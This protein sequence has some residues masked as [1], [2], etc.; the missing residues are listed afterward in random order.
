MSRRLKKI[1][2]L[3][4]L[5]ILF[6]GASAAEVFA[7]GKIV[8]HVKDKSTGEALI[9]VNIII[10]GSNL[11]AATDLEG[12]YTI[13]NVPVGQYTLKA[14]MV[15]ATSVS[16]QG[17]VVSTDQI[18]RVDF[19]LEQT[20][21]QGEEVVVTAPRDVL[22]K[23]VSSSQIVVDAKQLDETA[24]TR[25]LQ[26]FLNTQ[27]G[28]TDESYLE[29]R[30]GRPGETGTMV[31]GLTFVNA[32]VGKSEAFIPTSAI[33]QVSLKAGGMTAEYGEFRSGLIGVTTKTGSVTGYHGSFSFSKSPSHLKRFGPSLFDP[34]NNYLRPHL[35]PSIAFIGVSAAVQQGIISS[36]EAQQFGQYP[37][38]AGWNNL[39]GRNIPASW[40]NSLKPGE[41]ITPVDLYLFDAWMHTVVPDFNKLNSTIRD[42]NAQG[43]N[44][45]NEVTDQSLI[46]LFKN[47]ANKEDK[48]GDFNFD[49]GFGGP[50]PFL[51]QQLG[52]ATFYLSNITSRTS[53]I[54]PMELDYDLRSATLLTLKSNITQSLTLKLTG[55]YSYRKGMNPARAADSE[56]A[57]LSGANDLSPS[58][59]SNVY[60][61]LDRGALMPENNIPLFVSSGGNYGPTYYWYNTMLQPWEEKNI[62]TGFELT[63]A[64]SA[65]TFYEIT[66]SY[67]RTRDNINPDLSS[68][69]S[70]KIL[71]YIGPIP[72]TEMPYGRNQLPVGQSVDTIGGF[73][74]DQYFQIP[75]LSERFDSKGGS[76]YDN[77][78]TQQLRLKFDF[79]SQITKEHFIKAGVE[80]NSVALDNNRW[81]YWPNQGPLS[82]Y[83]YNFSVYP[84]NLGAFVQD[85]ITFEDMIAT[86]GVRMDYYSFG[87]LQW[88]TGNPWDADAFAPPN[89]TPVVDPNDSSNTTYYLDLLQNGQSLVWQHWNEINAQYIADGKSPFLQPVATHL[90]FSPRFGISFPIS[91]N[92]KFYFNYGHYRSMPPLAD[93]LAYDFR[94]DTQKGGIYELGNPNLA[95]SKTIQYELGVDY[96]LVDQYLIKIAGYYK[97]VSGDVRAITFRPNSGTGIGAYR[98][99]TNDSY[100]TIQGLELQITKNVGEILT[101]WLNL[102]YT[103]ASGGATG[104]TD[105]Y[106]DASTNATTGFYY[107]NPS[108]PYPVPEIRANINLRSP[109]SW[110]YILGGWNLSVLPNWRDGNRFTFNPRG[111]DEGSS[112][113][114]YWP[115]FWMV[116]L[117]VSKSFDVGL[118]R[119][120]AYLNVNNVFNSKQFLYNYAFYGGSG[121][122]SGTDYEYYMRSLHLADYQSSYYDPIRDETAGAYLYP[123]YVYT[124]NVT[125][126]MGISHS[127]GEKVSGEDKVGDMHSSS[128]PW[129]NSPNADLF[130]YGYTRSVWLGIKFDF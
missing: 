11:G 30:G 125:D 42:L 102:Q 126:A 45:G 34:M 29:I 53:Y 49:G 123:G 5:L 116:N 112:N 8:G 52:N 78:L 28:I 9:G 50:V 24:G 33:E 21:I 72:I 38:F 41:E 115:N 124:Q 65:S 60:S 62:L 43:L 1:F 122:A 76:Y 63:N 100:R 56:P 39:T 75:G 88:P 57:T 19:Q 23:D 48:Y 121:S 80:Y 84:R 96:S 54:Q 89:W 90:V 104:K 73:V 98:Y 71:G 14:S 107:A 79:G 36:Y 91:E 64:I 7:Q 32:R 118:L 4:I 106:E 22:H 6:L 51:S 18:T 101:G 40:T 10:V 127:P 27:A 105:F 95:P 69:R 15:G 66:G 12:D 31:N 81:S 3:S 82:M 13:V 97:D 93:M 70:N 16:Q 26:D 130:S 59:V 114:F 74:F 68:Q 99:R 77:S 129:I 58:G 92:A 109:D 61:G 2:C 94:F 110:G 120:T 128:K 87:N 17:V 111:T 35:D 86:I 55:L 113:Y 83:E 25:T 46:N 67:Q 47:H 85:Q 20:A 119:A 44:V 117:K 103:Y 37:S 108:R